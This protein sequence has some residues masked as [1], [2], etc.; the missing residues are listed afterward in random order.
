[1]KN[2]AVKTFACL[3]CFFLMKA[4][5]QTVSELLRQGVS[6][7]RAVVP[8]Y[9]TGSFK[10]SAVVRVDRAY[11]DYQ[12]KGFFRIGLLPI[13][14][15]DGVTYEARDLSSPAA[16]L[17]SLRRWL[18]PD[19]AKYVELRRVTLLLSPANRLE[20]GALR[21]LADGRWE[22]RNGV[23]FVSGANDL[24]AP[25]AT[26]QLTGSRVGQLILQTTPPTTNTLSML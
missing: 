25:S 1:M 26:L 3:L 9:T 20:A 14:V 15:L 4:G 2:T 11:M 18:G 24:R 13:G 21:C 8:L 12:R 10:L 7:Q 22:L 17:A 23:R 6:V 16:S 19:A 5:A